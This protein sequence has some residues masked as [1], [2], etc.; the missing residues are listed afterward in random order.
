MP[1]GTEINVS[2]NVSRRDN[3]TLESETSFRIL[4]NGWRDLSILFS[5]EIIILLEIFFFEQK[6]NIYSNIRSDCW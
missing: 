4:E 1:E 5:I 3:F 2:R 6:L